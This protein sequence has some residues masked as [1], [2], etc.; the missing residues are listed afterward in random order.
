MGGHRTPA[1]ECSQAG[2]GGGGRCLEGSLL[3][4]TAV[5]YFIKH[6]VR[7][8]VTQPPTSTKGLLPGGLLP[9]LATWCL[10]ASWQPGATAWPVGLEHLWVVPSK[11]GVCLLAGVRWWPCRP[12]RE[13]SAQGQGCTANEEEQIRTAASLERNARPP[14]LRRS[15]RGSWA[16]ATFWPPSTRA[17]T[18]PVQFVFGGRRRWPRRHAPLSG[19]GPVG[20]AEGAPLVWGQ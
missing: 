7:G 19:S 18:L 2:S 14:C 6:C 9:Q 16:R 11:G 12:S 3:Y 20:P 13:G 10:R 5:E 1:R 15:S 4:S 8:I 17:A